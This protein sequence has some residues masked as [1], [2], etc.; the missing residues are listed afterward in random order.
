MTDDK[1]EPDESLQEHSLKLRS[2]RDEDYEEIAAIMRLVYT[3]IKGG[4]AWPKKKYLA[5]L[6][7]FPEGQI[8]IEDSGKIVAA[9]LAVIVDYDKFG[10]DHTYWEITADPYLT[11]HDPNG[12]VMYGVDVFVHPDYRDLRLGRRLYDA[13]KDLCRKLNLKSIIAGG[14]IPRYADHMKELSPHEYIE[15]VSRREIYDPILTFQLS[16]DFEVKRLLEDYLP[17]D[18]ASKGYATL[19]EWTN[20]YCKAKKPPLLGGRKSIVRLGVVQWQMRTITSVD[21]LFQ[22][23]EY[24]VDA[25]AFYKADFCL[26]PEFFTAP[27]LCLSKEESQVDGVREMAQYSPEIKSFL[28]RLAV[29]YN[30][31]IIAGSLPVIEGNELYNV[32]YLC[33]RDGS[34]KAQQKL[35]LTKVEEKSWIMTGGD[36]LRVFDTDAGK[37]GIL[38]CYDVE[39]P[40]LARIQNQLGM[41]ILFVPFW[42]DT[43]NGYLRVQRCAQ[44]RAIENECYVA[45]SGS[46]GNLPKVD[47][48]EIQYAQSAVYSPS[49]FAFPHDA[50]IAETSPNTEMTLIV[51]LDM[52]KLDRLR[53]EGSVRNHLDRRTDL[54]QLKWIGESNKES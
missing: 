1:K 28:S 2:L 35:H 45:I 53:Y 18:N 42:T 23:I 11:T 52:D 49:D 17:E 44:A 40:E 8:C 47:N 31:N 29:S 46:V 50:V 26:F 9:A 15:K 5:M 3:E 7:A 54:Y 14:R 24:F 12:N 41:K 32:A 13:R 27:L 51:D 36:T 30:I 25:L 38:I 20:I 22:Q 4:G 43:K 10:D 19:L 6:H 21:A 33:Q 39:F 37:I 34:I 16:N 48:A